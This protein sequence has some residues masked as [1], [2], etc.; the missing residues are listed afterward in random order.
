MSWNIVQKS[1]LKNTIEWDKSQNFI[2]SEKKQLSHEVRRISIEL[3]EFII[4]INKSIKV[5]RIERK[6][7]VGWM[8]EWIY[9]R[10]QQII[11]FHIIVRVVPEDSL[12]KSIDFF[13]TES[14]YIKR[15]S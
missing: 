9:Y 15:N 13:P 4:D 3:N 12:L 11:Q 8:N 7:V 6:V 14:P 1:Q 5:E 2:Q 10:H